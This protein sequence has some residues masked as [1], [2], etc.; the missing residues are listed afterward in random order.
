MAHTVIEPHSCVSCKYCKSC[1]TNRGYVTR[2]FRDYYECN[3]TNFEVPYSPYKTNDC[4]TY[5]SKK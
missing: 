3:R 2:I 5:V 4:L 1:K